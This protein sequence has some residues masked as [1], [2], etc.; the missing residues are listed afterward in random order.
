M[1]DW[2]KMF[3][4]HLLSGV[5]NLKS[6]KGQGLVEYAL[7]LVLIAIVVIVIM[8]AL[9]HKTCEAFSTVNSALTQ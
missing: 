6:Q 4:L 3:Y 5:E 1:S 8:T 9:G 7:I 2:I